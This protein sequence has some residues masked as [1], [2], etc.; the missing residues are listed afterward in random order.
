M[1]GIFLALWRYRGFILGSVRREFQAKYAQSVLGASWAI[2]NPFAMILVY[3][4][5]LSSVMKARL[6][7]VDTAFAYSVYLCAGV[8]PWGFFAEIVSRG[9]GVFLENANL[10]KKLSFPRICLPAIVVL[11][12]GVN[13]LFAILIFLG[14]L[15]L[16][17]AFPTWGVLVLLPVLLVQTALAIGL[18]VLFGV[19]NVFFRDTAQFVGIALQFWFWFTPIVYPASALPE[20]V[21]AGVFN[22]NP[23][24]PIVAA[25]Q[26]VFVSQTTPVWQSLVYPSLFAVA[27]CALAMGVFRRHA[28]E[29]VDEL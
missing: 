21:A 28:G 23:M 16:L 9:H 3:T 12:A 1:S 18:G 26:G 6:P 5:V 8:L 14:F 27:V 20:Y 7:G 24:A 19:L 13:F 10:I 22:W 17:G 29:M 11:A 25:Y 2:L 15:A 4:I